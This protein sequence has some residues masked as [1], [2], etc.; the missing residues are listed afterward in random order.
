MLDA[1]VFD[2]DGENLILRIYAQPRAAKT[3]ITGVFGNALKIKVNSPPVDGKANTQLV[4]FVAKLFKVPKS[5]VELISG[6]K[7]REKRFRIHQ[8]EVL[9]ENLDVASR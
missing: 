9:P 6:E 4:Q 5:R 1:N 7:S 2:W 3:E 8:P